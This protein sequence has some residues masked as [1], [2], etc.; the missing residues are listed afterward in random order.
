MALPFGVY[1]GKPAEGSS[2]IRGRE[3]NY[4]LA[5][6][7]QVPG[8]L[9]RRF[10]GSRCETDSAVRLEQ[11]NPISERVGHVDAR[12]TCQRSGFRHLNAGLA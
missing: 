3:H 12:I 2:V 7:S 4:C 5:L 9:E 11:L 6:Y 1:R 10:W 8:F